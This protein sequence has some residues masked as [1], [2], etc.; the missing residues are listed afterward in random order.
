MNRNQFRGT[1]RGIAG[2]LEEETGKLI[3][4]RELQLRGVRKRVSGKAERIAG[5]AFEMVKAA[6]RPH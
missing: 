4:N 2:M 3:G 6:L 1:V 5:D